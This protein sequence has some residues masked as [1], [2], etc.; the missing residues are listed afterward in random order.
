[1]QLTG[2]HLAMAVDGT[3]RTM[4]QLDAEYDRGTVAFVIALEH[5]GTREI[6]R[7]DDGRLAFTGRAEFLSWSA[8]DENPALIEASKAAV[9]RR[10][11][12]MTSVFKGTGGF[13]GP[14]TAVCSQGG[15]GTGPHMH[16]IPTIWV[17]TGPWSL[18]APSFGE[19]ALDFDLLRDQLLAIGDVAVSLADRPVEEI[20]GRYPQLR[21]ERAAGLPTCMNPEP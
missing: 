18:W 7:R 21:A 10:H 19:G 3:A 1:M 16:L 4:P 12:P 20:A 17:I 8:P 15:L 2:G 9:K 5:L 11:L 14:R 6:E 13:G